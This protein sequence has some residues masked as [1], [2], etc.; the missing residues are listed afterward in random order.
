MK[1]MKPLETKIALL[2]KTPGVYILKNKKSII[3]YVGKAK[4]I[5]SRVQSYFK[6]HAGPPE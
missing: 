4:N 3:I 5:R 1:K 2:P 6:Q